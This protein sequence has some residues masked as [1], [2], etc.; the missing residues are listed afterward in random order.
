[1]RKGTANVARGWAGDLQQPSGLKCP[2]SASAFPAGYHRCHGE[3]SLVIAKQ[4]EVGAGSLC[5]ELLSR[6]REHAV[7]ARLAITTNG[8]S[9]EWGH[10]SS[11]PKGGA[12]RAARGRAGHLKH[13]GFFS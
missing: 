2:W 1:M 13:S 10:C 7:R 5:M 9:S 11:I 12:V 6:Q 3:S 8:V 4:D